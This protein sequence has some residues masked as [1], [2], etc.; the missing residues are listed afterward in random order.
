MNVPEDPS[1]PAGSSTIRESPNLENI[2]NQ[3]L[4]TETS[5]TVGSSKIA[6]SLEQGMK[7]EGSTFLCEFDVD[8][9]ISS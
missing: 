9:I 6:D 3:F 5:E 2:D 4:V 1:L 8:R 7:P